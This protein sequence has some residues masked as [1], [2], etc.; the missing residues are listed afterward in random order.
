MVN[1]NPGTSALQAQLQ[2]SKTKGKASPR[3]SPFIN[4]VTRTD[5]KPSFNPQK[6]SGK[7]S[8]TRADSVSLDRRVP[9]KT[10]TAIGKLSST[11][12]IDD[13]SLRIANFTGSNREAPTGRVSNE[14]LNQRHQPLGQ[15]IN[16]LV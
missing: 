5:N 10:S 4:N 3:P 12:E 8:A 9:V 6:T 7:P 11:D 1:V 13:A 16:I 14:N 2:A 15:I